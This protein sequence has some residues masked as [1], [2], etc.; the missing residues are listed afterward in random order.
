[1]FALPIFTGSDAT[2]AGGR[3][4][5]LSEW[6]IKG[7]ERVAAVDGRRRCSVTEDIRRVPQQD[8][9]P[10]TTLPYLCL[11]SVFGMAA[12]PSAACG[13]YSEGA[14]CAAVDS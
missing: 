1:M 10:A 7:A 8:S 14:V 12:S 9:H 5:E 6:Q 13:R 4:R 2:A 11:T 3:L